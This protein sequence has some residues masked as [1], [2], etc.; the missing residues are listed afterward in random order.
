MTKCSCHVTMLDA[1]V[2]EFWSEPSC[3]RVPIHLWTSLG[4]STCRVYCRAS[5]ALLPTHSCPCP[6]PHLAGAGPSPPSHAPRTILT[7]S[8]LFPT[9]VFH[10]S[11]TYPPRLSTCPC[12][13]ELLDLRPH[14][15]ESS[16][17]PDTK[18][19]LLIW[20]LARTLF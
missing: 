7:T 10:S 8:C 4:Q 9:S 16:S 5:Q 11:L 3:L 13:H 17:L 20:A 19:A 12:C 6:A 1:G 2:W 14:R 15:Y 18:R